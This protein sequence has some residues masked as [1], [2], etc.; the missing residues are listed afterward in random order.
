MLKRSEAFRSNPWAQLTP[1]AVVLALVAS[2]CQ[3]PFSSKKDP[4]Q[5]TDSQER[6]P[7]VTE[8]EED[9]SSWK[10]LTLLGTNDIHGSVE[11]GR[12]KDGSL[13]GGFAFWAG[14]VRSI[15]QGVE[16]RYGAENSGVLVLDGGDQ[17]QGSLLSNYNEGQLVYSLMSEVGYDAIVPGN[18]AYDFGP[19]GWLEDKV[20]PTS[21]DQNPR[22]ALERLVTLAKFPLLSANTYVKS[23]LVDS[24][25]EPVAVDGIGCEPVKKVDTASV[26]AETR[27]IQWNKTQ[28]PAFLKPYLIKQV[29]GVRVALIGL[30]NI[31]TPQTTTVENVQD[32]CFRS[33]LDTYLEIRRELEGRAE[34]FVLLIHDGNSG[35]DKGASDLV[36]KI[37]AKGQAE[38]LTN[39]IHAVVAGHTHTVNRVMVGQVPLMQSGAHL[40]MF[41]RIDLVWDAAKKRIV[42]AQ[43]RMAAGVRL[44]HEKCASEAKDF[45]SV[46]EVEK[47]VAYDQTRVESVRPIEALIEKGKEELAPQARRKLGVAKAEITRHRIAESPLANALTDALRSASGAEVAMMNTGGIRDNLKAGDVTYEDLFRVLPFNNHGV[48]LEP[49]KASTLLALMNKSIKTCGSYG[50]LMQSGLRVTF[51]RNCKGAREGDLDRKARLLK[52]ET[53]SGEVIYERADPAIP[54]DENEVL[55]PAKADR[56]FKAATLD[57][58]ASGGSGYGEFKDVPQTRDLGIV[59][60]VFTEEYL[61]NPAEFSERIDGR[62]KELERASAD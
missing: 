26:P 13:Q 31:T 16:A 4:S 45:C 6:A 39:V 20:T 54:S 61:K 62:W 52:V 27:S 29:A 10:Y 58:L 56:V 59:R 9:R 33:E 2:A 1:V 49:M 48:V 24:E 60:E 17:F 32:L 47:K 53:L 38:G 40:E 18:H 44:F 12:T 11:A 35:E 46:V 22:G 21:E 51:E 34:V 28:R 42:P 55:V 19:K 7:K 14:V 8:P 15:R 37:T 30:D 36:A 41:G 57:F 25:G 5:T 50:A 3:S 23:S 43:T